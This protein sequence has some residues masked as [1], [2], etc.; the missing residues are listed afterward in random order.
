MDGDENQ[1]NPY[2]QYRLPYPRLL[3][4]FLVSVCAFATLRETLLFARSPLF[5]IRGDLRK[6][7]ANKNPLPLRPSIFLP[8][9][10][11][12]TQSLQRQNFNFSRIDLNICF[13][14]F[15]LRLCDFA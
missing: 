1:A 2:L 6:S 14:C 9:A 7:V 8:L 13:L 15:S 12:K 4:G 11:L 10:S 3:N 5:F